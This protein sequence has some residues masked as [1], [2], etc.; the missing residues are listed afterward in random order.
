MNENSKTLHFKVG[1]FV[2]TG[3]MIIGVMVV[4]FG[5]IGQGFHNYYDLT[6]NFSNASGIIKRADVQFAGVRIGYVEKVPDIG[7][8]ATRIPVYLKVKEGTV[9]PRETKFQ[10]SSNGLLGDKFVEV[11]PTEKFDPAQYDPKDPKQTWHAGEVIA[12]SNEGGLQALQKKGED[13][14][15]QLKQEIV[16]LQKVTEKINGGVLSEANQKNLA[17]ML[18][19][20]KTTSESFV[21]TSKNA[22]EVMLNVNN[23]VLH[24]QGAIDSAKKGL[25]TID[26]AAGD[27]R[28]TIGDGQKMISSANQAIQL[29]SHGNGLLPSLLN[30]PRL[31]DNVKALSANLRKHGI[32]FYKDSASNV[33]LTSGTLQPPKRR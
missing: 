24:A 21:T 27:L 13:V 8:D 20:L 17:S 16:E 7:L 33:V 9:I 29:V 32:L 1:L 3:L 11:V 5:Q 22:N 19:N 15:D 26:Q 2:F 12:G 14:L 31:S 4:K 18:S 25:T 30:D 28:K 6:V 10:V 23:T